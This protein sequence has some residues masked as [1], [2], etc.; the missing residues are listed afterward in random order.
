MQPLCRA[1]FGEL[2][3]TSADVVRAQSVEAI[4]LTEADMQDD[5]MF[6]RLC[7]TIEQ[8]VYEAKSALNHSSRPA[9]VKVLSL[10]E[11]CKQQIDR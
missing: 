4:E 11:M 5:L 10:Y 3:Y 7:M 6:K 2:G 9:G 8:L 1:Q